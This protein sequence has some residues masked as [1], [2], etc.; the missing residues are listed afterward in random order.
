MSIQ[1]PSRAEMLRDKFLHR[2]N[3]IE[4]IASHIEIEENIEKGDKNDIQLYDDYSKLLCD[5][6]FRHKRRKVWKDII[7]W[8]SVPDKP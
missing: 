6:S 5:N 3:E 8:T 1:N 4:T 7:K 2:L